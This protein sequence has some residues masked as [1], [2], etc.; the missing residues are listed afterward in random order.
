MSKITIP[1][2]K[3]QDMVARAAKG[4]SENKLLPIT[5]MMC[6][7]VEDNVLSLTTT[8]S[9]NTLTIRANKIEGDD[10]YAVVPVAQFSKLIAKTSSDSIKLVVKDG[11]IE[12]HGNGVHRIAQPVDEDGVV[13]F[14]KYNF[15]KQDGYETLLLSDVKSVLSVNKASVATTIDTPCLCAYYVGKQ[16]VSTDEMTI[17]FYDKNILSG[18]Y[19][20]SAE[21]MEL[22]AL[23]K[24]EEITT[25]YTDGYFLFETDDMVLYGPEHDEK[26]LFP[27]EDVDSFAE[28]EIS[29]YCRV[30]KIALQGLI[31]RLA[32]FIEPYDKNGAY[33]TFT[34]EGLKINSKKSNSDEIIP[35]I[36]SKN[37][38]PFVCCADIPMLK[39]LVDAHPAESI[40][41]WYGDEACLKMTSGTATQVIALLEDDALESVQG[42]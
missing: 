23:A 15:E 2:V 41:L 37:F 33:L 4:A 13:Q 9:A 28:L 32:L 29:S 20:I 18:P 30:P 24:Q 11:E 21:M 40:D 25:Y 8:D 39:R 27:I 19:L 16:V 12:V 7:K 17:C 5:S 6:I 35:Y 36:E 38:T 3:F 1:T 22:V 26:D 10:M 42:E 31:D 34:T 14:P